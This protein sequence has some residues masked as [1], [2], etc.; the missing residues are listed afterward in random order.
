MSLTILHILLQQLH[1]RVPISFTSMLPGL[2]IIP[3][4][5]GIPGWFV[6]ANFVVRGGHKFA[7]A[8]AAVAAAANDSPVRAPGSGDGLVS[9]CRNYRTTFCRSGKVWSSWIV[10]RTVK[11][12]PVAAYRAPWRLKSSTVNRKSI[13]HEPLYEL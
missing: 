8:A 9:G 5:C 2:L 6:S 4:A 3:L 12:G 7:G 11:R 1:S 10:R 13:R